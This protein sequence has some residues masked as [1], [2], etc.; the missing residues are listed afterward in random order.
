MIVPV[1]L[2]LC[3]LLGQI[4]SLALLAPFL[5]DLQCIVERIMA[6][7]HGPWPGW[8]WRQL[9]GGW[10]QNT[11]I[12]SLSWM[13]LCATLLAGLSLPF[14]STQIPFHFLSEPL[15]CG[16]LL[17]I[18]SATVWAQALTHAPTRMIQ[19]RL[20]SSVGALGHDLLFLVSLLTLTGTLITVG[21]P[22]S[23]TITGLLQQ[24]LLQPAPALMGG[25]VFIAGAL[26]LILNRRLL[27]QSWHE[28]LISG[29]EGRHRSLLRYQHDLSAMCWYLLVADLIW[30]DSIATATT[31]PGQLALLWCL[32]APVKLGL[33]VIL[34]TA[35]RMIRPLPSARLALVL[36][37]AAILLVVA[38]RLAA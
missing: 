11:P 16:L 21:L 31:P 15:A 24:R 23:A 27:S 6:G 2:Q 26:L 20:T 38:G 36:S 3:V 12:S 5:T 4:L 10:R 8:R 32:A 29:A 13:G 22:G 17:I 30:P 34:A 19:L 33:L 35:W 18:S 7:R 1:A 9:R 14:A 37:G 28:M 25:L